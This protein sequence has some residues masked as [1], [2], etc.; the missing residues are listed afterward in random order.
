M[1]RQWEDEVVAA[2]SARLVAPAFDGTPALSLR[3]EMVHLWLA[4]TG[5]RIHT[6]ARR[7]F[8]SNT[9]SRYLGIAPDGVR[10]CAGPNGKPILDPDHHPPLHFNLAHSGE[11]AL[12]AVARRRVGVDLEHTRP[13]PEIPGL[14]D[15]F[16]ATGEAAAIA[17]LPASERPGAFFRA[18]TK[19]EAYLKALGDGVAQGPGLAELALDRDLPGWTIT[20]FSP[21]PDYYG[22]LAVESALPRC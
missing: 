6:V 15:R 19:K 2:P 3:D 11:F 22:A 13:L 10:I 16:L 14:I 12:L 21:I 20:S 9:L 4:R 5:P 1:R 7:R 18:W 8:V 17:A